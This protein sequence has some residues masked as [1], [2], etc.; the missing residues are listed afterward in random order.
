M[1]EEDVGRFD[2]N[3]YGHNRDMKFLENAQK[4]MQGLPYRQEPRQQGLGYEP[5][6]ERNNRRPEIE[7]EVRQ[8]VYQE[9]RREVQR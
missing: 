4:A 7:R 2:N 3:W 1:D 9:P 5:S 6:W 8:P